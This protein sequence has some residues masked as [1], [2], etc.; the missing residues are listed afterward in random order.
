MRKVK[1]WIYIQL[2]DKNIDFAYGEMKMNAYFSIVLL[3]ILLF[4]VVWALGWILEQLSHVALDIT[5]S[6]GSRAWYALVGPGVALHESSHGLGC[7]FT[8]TEIVEFKPIN[9]SVQGDQVVLGYVSYRD[10][11][12]VFKKAI[13]NLAPVGVSLVLL[14]FFALAVTYL[15]P[16][17][18]GIGGQ[19]LIL[20]QDLIDVKND[21]VLLADPVYPVVLILG[22]VYSFFYTFAGLTVISP[23]FWIVAFLAMTIMFSNAPSDVDIKN[24]LP[25]LKW[26][27]LFNVIWLVVAYFLPIAGWALFGLY[28]LLA[29]MFALAVAFSVLAYG[30]FIMITFMGKLKI[31]FNVLP[32]MATIVAG[33]ILA[34]IGYGTP[35]FQTVISVAVFVLIALPLLMIKSLRVQK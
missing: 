24:A 30:F 4:F 2:H 29:V 3:A 7:L 13:I 14:T 16:T 8:G 22:F 6:P 15:V 19:A 25:G 23:I 20:L 27:M 26:I 5:R 33:F 18:P 10:P 21:A 17:S 11:K 35:A 31:P 32:F 1:Y 9:V 12:S 34:S 28:E